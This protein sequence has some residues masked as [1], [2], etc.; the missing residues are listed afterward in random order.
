[1]PSDVAPNDTIFPNIEKNQDKSE[2]PKSIP[3]IKKE[4][5][6]NKAPVKVKQVNEVENPELKVSSK[7]VINKPILT[8]TE[9]SETVS[10]EHTQ[11]I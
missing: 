6:V 8:K 3:K 2:K 5:R 11:Q 7:K 1:M 9:N 4:Q 10:E